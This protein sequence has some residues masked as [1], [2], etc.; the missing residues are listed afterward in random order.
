[1]IKYNFKNIEIKDYLFKIYILIIQK[2]FKVFLKLLFLIFNSFQT[3]KF[4]V[5]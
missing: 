4:Y 5:K 2:Y 1:M 3:R